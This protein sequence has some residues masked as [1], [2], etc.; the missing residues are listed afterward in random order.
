MVSAD[1]LFEP[2]E[3]AAG[4]SLSASTIRTN[5]RSALNLLGWNGMLVIHDLNGPLRAVVAWIIPTRCGI[6]I[7]TSYG[8]T[9]V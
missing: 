4:G 1:G 8:A 6:P 5:L 3:P 2:V 9:H 7:S